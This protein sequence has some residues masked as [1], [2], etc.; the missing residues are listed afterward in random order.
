VSVSDPVENALDCFDAGDIL[1]AEKISFEGLF[2]NLQP[3]EIEIGCGKGKFLISR[4]EQCP[5]INFL[6]ID[7][8]AK[9][10]KAGQRKKGR[11]NLQNV[12]FFRTDIR[13]VL[14]KTPLQSIHIFHLYFPDPWPKRR[15]RPR[16][17]VTAK[18][19]QLLHSRLLD[20]G[21]IE[22]ATD[23]ADYFSQ[24]K[25]EAEALSFLWREKRESRERFLDTAK[26]S[27]EIKYESAGRKLY[28]LELKAA[29]SRNGGIGERASGGVEERASGR[30]KERE[31]L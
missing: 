15:H 31:I 23:D 20:G 10:M 26:T 27:Y 4:A 21:L 2:R 11:L 25:A 28:Y 29:I 13:L 7:R 5:G 16:R 30:A 8:V 12:R 9:W 14:E 24:M 18:F 17:L 19:L 3:V 1:R 6:G 22:M